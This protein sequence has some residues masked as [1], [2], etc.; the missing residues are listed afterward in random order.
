MIGRETR[1]GFEL[2]NAVDIAIGTNNYKA[3]RG[4]AVLAAILDEVAFY[5]SESSS[6]PDIETY[7]ALMPGLATLPGSMLIGISSPYRR[8]GLLH[9]KYKDQQLTLRRIV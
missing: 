5:Q 1:D 2:S 9:Q 3:V 6:S 7:R 8:A 4:R